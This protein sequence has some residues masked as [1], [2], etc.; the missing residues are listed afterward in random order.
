MRAGL[1]GLEVNCVLASPPQNRFYE[2]LQLGWDKSNTELKIVNIY[3]LY[4][5]NN[6]ILNIILDGLLRK[7]YDII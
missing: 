3:T 7:L 6:F 4:F 2:M 1:V 5:T